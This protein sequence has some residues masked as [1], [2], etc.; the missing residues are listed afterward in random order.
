MADKTYD[1]LREACDGITTYGSFY[2]VMGGM[3]V[4]GDE[5]R[6]KARLLYPDD[7]GQRKAFITHAFIGLDMAFG[8]DNDRRPQEGE[9]VFY[10]QFATFLAV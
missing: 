7:Y 3:M 2:S 4:V 9:E 1:R 6:T 5:L 10:G 8:F